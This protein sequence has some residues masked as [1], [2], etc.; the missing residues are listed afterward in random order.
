MTPPQGA[1]VAPALLERLRKL[2]QP[3]HLE[4]GLHPDSSPCPVC[5]RARSLLEAL[6]PLQPHVMVEIVA[7]ILPGQEGEA[8]P[9]PWIRILEAEG[10][11]RYLGVPSHRSLDAFIAILEETARGTLLPPGELRGRLERPGPR[12][13]MRLF[14]SARSGECS[15]AMLLFARTARTV[16]TRL[17][18]DV[19]DVDDLPTLTRT[20]GVK[21]LPCATVGDFAHVH[22]PT[23]E[24]DLL[25]VLHDVLP[26]GGWPPPTGV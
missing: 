15:D 6:R 11:Q 17:R 22:A 1:E 2:P 16:P 4:A 19:I 23:S 13:H 5:P 10:C 8:A 26:S 9:S 25:R 20:F 21:T 12:L 3:I 7:A 18:L 14:I 24:E